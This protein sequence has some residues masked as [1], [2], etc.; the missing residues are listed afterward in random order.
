MENTPQKTEGTA[1]AALREL[2]IPVGDIALRCT[3][4]VPANGAE[5]ET[6]GEARAD[7]TVEAD[8]AAETG[9]GAKPLSAAGSGPVPLVL[10]HGNGG[11]ADAFSHQLPWFGRTRRVLAPDTRGHGGS[12]RG[13]APF[14]LAQFADDLAALLEAEGIRQADVLGFSDGGNIA[15]LFALKYP[16]RVHRLV[17]NSANLYP[18]GLVRPFW[19]GVVFSALRAKTTA[20]KE[21]LGL[22]AWQ[23]HIRFAQLRALHMPALVIAGDRDLIRARHTRRI[24]AALPRGVLAVLPGTHGVLGERPEIFNGIVGAFLDAGDLDAE[25]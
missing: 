6:N 9:S 10:L 4:A 15:L 13:S 11:S 2:W 5:A 7:G 12:P 1:E 23:P 21:M 17:L 3:E 8:R 20:Q 19:P 18:G 14:A 22:M 25:L 24:A 16:D